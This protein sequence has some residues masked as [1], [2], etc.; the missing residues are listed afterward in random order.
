MHE[1]VPLIE[2]LKMYYGCGVWAGKIF[3][4]IAAIDYLFLILLEWLNPKDE[5]ELAPDFSL[6]EY[7]KVMHF[8]NSFRL[9]EK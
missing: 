2:R 3:C 8:V 5:I 7:Q 9:L 6:K 4:M 1:N